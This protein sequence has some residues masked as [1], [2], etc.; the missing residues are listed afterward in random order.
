[1]RKAIILFIVGITSATTI[2][3]QGFVETEY[4]S[5]SDMNDKA[6]NNHGQGDMFRVKGRYTM[7]LSVRM[8]EDN[9]P[10][11]WTATMSASYATMSNKGEAQSLNPSEILN[12]SLNISHIRPVS[13]R[14]QLI[15]SIGAGIYTVPRELARRSILANGAAIMAYRFSDNLSAG[16]GLGLTNSYGPPLL[17]PMCYMAW[18]T[19]GNIKIAVDMAN[20]M[21]VRASASITERVGLELTAIEIDGMSAVRRIDGKD[22]I[23][24]SMMMRSALTS[25]YRL[26]EKT[27]FRFAIGGT[28]LRTAT[29]S[30]RSLKGFFS[31]FGD[32]EGKYRFRPSIRL[33]LG[34]SYGL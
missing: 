6:G 17:M 8:N 30:D 27:K 7:P 20:S 5:A 25:T 9:R 10:T 13:P 34:I 24:S 12:A 1:M 16:I 14:W 22:K 2:N 4:L 31:S 32:D 15:A 26:T 18:R 29:L 21:T 19:R 11:A 23:Y 33:S 3:A 28:W